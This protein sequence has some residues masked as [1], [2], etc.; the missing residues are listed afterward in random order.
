MITFLSKD[1]V[2]RH[3]STLHKM[4]R[5]RK[6][7]FSDRLGWSVAVSGDLEFDEYDALGPV[8]VLSETAEGELLGCVRL[9]PTMG[10]YMLRD[11]FAVLLDGSEAPASEL[12]WEASRF[13][14]AKHSVKGDGGLARATYELLIGVLQFSLDHDIEAIVCVVDLRMERVLRRAGWPMQR[15]GPE[16][17]V[18]STIA[19]AGRLEVSERLLH[20]LEELCEGCRPTAGTP[21]AGIHAPQDPSRW[22]LRSLAPQPIAAQPRSNIVAASQDFWRN[23]S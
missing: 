4:H 18:G 10:S 19:A 9:L 5:L 12:V 2:G 1:N 7:V 22:S 3:I 17:R 16:R 6:Q 15:L 8:Y 20:G 13:A 21:Q 14:V 23:A 11:T